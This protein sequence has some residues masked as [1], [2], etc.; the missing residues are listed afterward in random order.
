MPIFGGVVTFIVVW[1][2]VLFMVLPFGIKSQAETKIHIVKGTEIGA[3][4][5]PNL[6]F[7]FLLTTLIALGIWGSFFLLFYYHILTIDYFIQ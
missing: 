5:K 1:W 7:K 2:I 4:E 3:P 6:K